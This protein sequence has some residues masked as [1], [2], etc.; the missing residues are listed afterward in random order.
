MTHT[1]MFLGWAFFLFLLFLTLPV[2]FAENASIV[3]LYSDSSTA[4]EVHAADELEAYLGNL[5]GMSVQKSRT[6][7][8][9]SIN[10]ARWVIVVGRPSTPLFT[11]LGLNK[12]FD[13]NDSFYV[14]SLIKNNQRYVA[15]T[16]LNDRGVLYGSYAFIEWV[17]N[18][19]SAVKYDYVDID[20]D[21]VN[22][23]AG[24]LFSGDLNVSI[25]SSPFFSLRGVEM[26]VLSLGVGDLVPG[27][28]D[29][30][31]HKWTS[32]SGIK[33]G[34][35]KTSETWT[36]W[37]DWMGRHRMNFISNWP[38]TAGFNWWEF[39]VNDSLSNM[40]LW[41]VSEINQ[42]IAVRRQLLNYSKA[43]GLDTYFNNYVP[44]RPN[45]ATV[46]NRSDLLQI[47]TQYDDPAN[48]YNVTG[49]NLSKVE[50]YRVFKTA[51]NEIIKTY[52]ELSGF[53]F[54]FWGESFADMNQAKD[55]ASDM[56]STAKMA[57]PDTKI[58][59][60]GGGITAEYA[61][62]LPD[63]AIIQQKWGG[64]WGPTY[65]PGVSYNTITAINRDFLICFNLP[66]EESHPVGIAMP[67]QIT[68]GV[69]KYA[70][71]MSKAPNLRG[72]VIPTGEKD[73][74]W[75]TELNYILMA[76]LDWDPNI[77]AEKFVKDYLK[78][79]YGPGAE[80]YIY[81]S[82][83]LQDQMIYN[84]TVTEVKCGGFGNINQANRFQDQ[85][86]WSLSKSTMY[87]SSISAL[88]NL[89]LNDLTTCRNKMK[90]LSILQEEA[91]DLMIE[92][93]PSISSGKSQERYDDLLKQTRIFNNFL[94]SRVAL[95]EGTIIAKHLDYYGAQSKISE[96]ITEDNLLLADF[97]S[98]KN[99]AD[100]FEMDGMNSGY[101]L[102]NRVN[103][104]LGYLGKMS[105][106][107]PSCPPGSSFYARTSN[108][109]PYT[110][111]I[112]GYDTAYR[113][114]HWSVDPGTIKRICFYT[115]M[116][117]TLNYVLRNSSNGTIIYSGDIS[118]SSVGWNCVNVSH[119]WPYTSMYLGRPSGTAYV[120]YSWVDSGGN[121][122]GDIAPS[123]TIDRF[124]GVCL[125]P[126]DCLES[127][128]D[129]N[130]TC[131]ADCGASYVCDGLA[132]MAQLS[133]CFGGVSAG[134]HDRCSSKCQSEDRPDNLCRKRGIS[135]CAG[136]S[137]C[138][139]VSVGACSATPMR[140]CDSACEEITSCGDGICN[141]AE[142]A[143]ICPEDCPNYAPKGFFDYAG[144][145]NLLGWS[146]DAN[147]Y[148]SS[149]WIHFYSGGPAGTGTFIGA[150]SAN[151]TRE[152]A[153]GVQCGGQTRHGFNYT[154][155]ATLK[156]SQD[157]TLYAY[158]I[159]LP[160]GSNYLLGNKTL[161][162]TALTTTTSSSTTTTTP[163][164]C[165]LPGNYP[166][167]GEVS[168]N[169]VVDAI[170][171]WALSNLELGKVVDLINSW[172]DPTGHPPI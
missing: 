115:N 16:G 75:I 46:Q 170:N 3:I 45:Y 120:A 138:D 55:L 128:T 10:G 146:C 78:N 117:G 88:S 168:L 15:V 171:Q 158:A 13:V 36:D 2:A 103:T 60:S 102:T 54:R 68:S 105:F 59:V 141:C 74:G 129:M 142:N 93:G 108:L 124:Y 160:A 56:I 79:K 25:E 21:Y 90:E 38:Y 32:Y 119:N 34:Y 43:R 19:S 111:M 172:A 98:K 153:V 163:L 94:K 57:D 122:Y 123:E 152:A 87:Y 99:I 73:F 84:L 12:S 143:S 162:C 156:D 114:A 62:S 44:G 92:A 30:D 23:Q 20:Y 125:Q 159:N 80:D 4:V 65:D 47:H 82:L 24:D 70:G 89:S 8:L 165:I 140:I 18:Q 130:G 72:F 76:K 71:N 113:Y 155:P 81:E 139:S 14:K 131:K 100:D 135:D 41:S 166:P 33:G 121:S 126:T 109:T 157:H 51:I 77:D 161:N 26:Q 95:F 133:Y 134:V 40:S 154:T 48:P 150:A 104:E 17:I 151:E 137:G 58:L 149:L 86:Y 63:D 107:I 85:F 42:G 106:G 144:C 148:S 39:V 35:N 116:S 28:F 50:T 132:P 7:V 101:L 53:H 167:C 27:C 37:S 97:S 118:A 67:F 52:P 9:G 169:E 91:T 29:R 110:S 69:K 5:S 1:D 164:E 127:G 6:D 22:G 66:T 64:D 136:D 147:D 83:E 145:D 49:F 112:D 96:A 61:N 31:Q 11:Q